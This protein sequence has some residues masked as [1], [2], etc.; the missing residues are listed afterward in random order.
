MN[1]PGF[2]FCGSC[3][4]RQQ[5]S[6]VSAG[7]A[8]PGPGPGQQGQPLGQQ[9]MVSDG[10]GVAAGAA[11]TM[12]P[13][14]MSAGMSAADSTG[15]PGRSRKPLALL[16]M[17]DAALAIAGGLLLRAGLARPAEASAEPAA[18]A[19]PS[20]T[21][22]APAPASE[23]APTS[24]TPAPVQSA[25]PPAAAATKGNAATG[26]GGGSAAAVVVGASPPAAAA[27]PSGF[28]PGE[29]APGQPADAN[30]KTTDDGNDGNDGS[31][32]SDAAKKKKKAEKA[33][34][35]RADG[36]VDPYPSTAPAAD[37][38]AQISKLFTRGQAK[39]DKCHASISQGAG[40]AQLTIS[41]R[42][43]ADGTLGGTRVLGAPPGAEML[44]MCVVA[45][46]AKWKVKSG[47]SGEF[48][49]RIQFGK[50]R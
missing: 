1:E 44:S 36:P 30:D 6:V 37:L 35:P 47:E 32:G 34:R 27:P 29:L 12:R 42:V 18:E 17:V 9:A 40:P 2:R 43:M 25:A 24:A 15:L 48:V 31:D 33:A 5:D 10:I 50:A 20:S 49:R 26:S 3:G 28:A 46:L 39:L 11:G 41:F 16:L 38:S 7:A 4:A 45:E 14:R 13:R 8:A 19:A 21:S 22:A 23:P